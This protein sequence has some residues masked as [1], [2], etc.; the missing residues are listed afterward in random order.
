MH[1]SYV[2]NTSALN[3]YS[4]MNYNSTGV[5]IVVCDE[6]DIGIELADRLVKN[7]AR[8]IVLHT[9]SKISGYWQTKFA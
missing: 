2:F 5:Y 7:G 1:A 8:K 9:R 4:R 6:N 3:F